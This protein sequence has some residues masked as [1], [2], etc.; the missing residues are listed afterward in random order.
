MME[1]S[2]SKVVRLV[3]NHPTETLIIYLG[4][5]IGLLSFDSYGAEKLKYTAKEEVRSLSCCVIIWP[6]SRDFPAL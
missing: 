2:S 4:I 5:S 1:F 3:V 6:K